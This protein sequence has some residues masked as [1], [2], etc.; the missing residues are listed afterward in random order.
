MQ[1]TC[2]WSVLAVLLAHIDKICILLFSEAAEANCA[3]IVRVLLVSAVCLTDVRFCQQ[4]A[5]V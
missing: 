3:V 1:Y 2:R 4:S 5:G